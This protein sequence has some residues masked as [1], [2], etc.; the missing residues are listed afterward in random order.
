MKRVTKRVRAVK[1]KKAV[2]HLI[3]TSDQHERDRLAADRLRSVEFVA[4]G[5]REEKGRV[6]FPAAEQFSAVALFEEKTLRPV[7]PEVFEEALAKAKEDGRVWWTDTGRRRSDGEPIL[8]RREGSGL[9]DCYF[10][11]P[12]WVAEHL[13]EMVE[14]GQLNEARQ[15]AGAVLREVGW[16][17]AKR[18][19]YKPVG[20][21]LH[22]DSRGA[23]GFHIQF[24]T[25]SQGKLLGRSANGKVGRKGLRLLGDAMLAV[26][27]FGE[28]IGLDGKAYRAI[29]KKDYDDVALDKVMMK[30]LKKKFKE[31]DLEK[32]K[33]RGKIY[34]ENWKRKRDEALAEGRKIGRLERENKQLR[35]EI[36]SLKEQN[37][38]LVG[39]GEKLEKTLEGFKRSL[40]DMQ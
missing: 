12:P 23:L 39:R 16:E 19:G 25:A 32:I 35:E 31:K 26:S 36:S 37:Q 2:K 7:A 6:P 20:G 9:S 22:P 15:I 30:T 4:V 27:R 17:L 1:S 5:P 11:F 18:T 8:Q 21:A 34:A 24:Q 40:G 38:R 3:F 13:A 14:A 29:N 28:F 10:S 33:E